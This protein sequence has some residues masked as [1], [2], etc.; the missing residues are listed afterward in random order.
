MFFVSSLNGSQIGVTDTD[1]GVEDF[2]SKEDLGNIVL[3]KGMRINGFTHTGSDF[4]IEVK[5][6]ALIFLESIPNGTV[7][8]LNGVPAMRVDLLSSRN[9][10]V[11]TANKF[12]RLQRRDLLQNKYIIHK[13]VSDADRKALV[14]SYISRYPS[15]HLGLMLQQE[16]V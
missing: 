4:R 1:D 9:F 5:N 3:N 16:R 6:L 10:N 8:L 2:F 11:F 12:M 13:Q 7:F 14:G 15:T